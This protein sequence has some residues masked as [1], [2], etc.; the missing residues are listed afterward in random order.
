MEAY[1]GVG[2]VEGQL[3]K[4]LFGSATWDSVRVIFNSTNKEIQTE[5]SKI[6]DAAGDATI[7]APAF[8]D[9]CKTTTS[10]KRK[11]NDDNAAD[12]ESPTADVRT[13]QA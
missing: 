7:E 12:A 10:K 8:G 3:V 4:A 6:N 13:Q 9:A 11:T 5:L 2:P 1:S